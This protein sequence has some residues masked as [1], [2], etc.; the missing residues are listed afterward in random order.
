MTSSWWPQMDLPFKP[1]RP[2]WLRVARVPFSAQQTHRQGL[3][4]LGDLSNCAHPAAQAGLK[5]LRIQPCDHIGNEVMRGDPIGEGRKLAKP[6]EFVLPKLLNRFPTD[7]RNSWQRFSY[8]AATAFAGQFYI[9]ARYGTIAR[10]AAPRGE[11]GF[12][13]SCVAPPCFHSESVSK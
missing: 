10:S 13:P 4:D 8:R 11:S 3:C 12:W 6:V 7:L 9:R 1:A 5:R 2:I